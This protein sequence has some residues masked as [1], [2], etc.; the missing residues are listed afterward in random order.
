MKFTRKVLLANLLG[1]GIILAGCANDETSEHHHEDHQE[2][3]EHH[4]HE[5]HHSSNNSR[6]QVESDGER[7]P[8]AFNENA[9]N[10][11]VVENTKNITRI[12]EEDPVTASIFVSQTVWPATHEQN[13]PGTV[14]LAPVDDWQYSLAALTLVHHPNDGPLLFVDEEISDHVLMEI[15]RLQPK[16]NDEGTQVLVIGDYDEKELSKLNGFEVKQIVGENPADF[17]E[18]I[19]ESFFETIGHVHQAVIIG[20]ADDAAKGY[21]VPVGNWIAHMNESLLYVEADTVPQE[22]IKALEKREGKAEIY[23]VG[24]EEIISEEVESKLEEYGTVQRISG[25]NEI[26][27]SIA[28]S[29]FKDDNNFGWGITTPGHG[30]VFVSTESPELAIVAAPFAHLGKHAPMVWLEDGEVTKSLYEYLAKLK[31][32]FTTDPT[33]GPYNHGYVLGSFDLIPFQTQGILDE[34]LEIVSLE[35]NDHAH[36]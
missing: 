13:Q 36:H 9:M 30:L 6:E 16:G 33:E 11:L 32:A 10:G 27:Q 12:N 19:E 23:I 5:N 31:P 7:E 4:E 26:E 1:A 2:I 18:K 21:T 8:N 25:D 35:G 3:E 14:I 29:S 24:P 17:A 15:N 22:T 34:K 20:S 28:F